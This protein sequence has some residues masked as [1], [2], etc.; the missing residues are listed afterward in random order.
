LCNIKDERSGEGV[1]TEDIS[2][3]EVHEIPHEESQ[4][5]TR[6]QGVRKTQ[7]EGEDQ[8]DIRSD[9]LNGE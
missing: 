5:S 9:P 8:D 6:D 2:R 4:D 1:K 7:V 3:K